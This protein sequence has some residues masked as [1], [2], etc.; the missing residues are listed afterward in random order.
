MCLYAVA[1]VEIIHR[2]ARAA[3]TTSRHDNFDDMREIS[4]DISVAPHPR[5]PLARWSSLLIF[6]AS[7]LFFA[8]AIG[9]NAPQCFEA[10][11]GG[12][13]FSPSRW[14]L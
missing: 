4:L 11:A 6:S 14:P 2:G 13:P 12:L 7:G 10:V 3:P 1:S 8:L 5:S 9:S